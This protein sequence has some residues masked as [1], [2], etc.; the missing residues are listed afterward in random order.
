GVSR[1]ELLRIRDFSLFLGSMFAT[2]LALQMAQVAVGWQVY[3]INHRPL[4]LGLVGLA[5]FIPLPLLALPAGQLADRL[6][7]RALV[8]AAAGLGA[9]VA[10]GLLVVTLNGAN[11]VGPYFALAFLTGVA[12]AIGAPPSR[13][14]TPSLVPRE[15]LSSAFALRAVAFQV[16]AIAGPAIGG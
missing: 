5:E 1:R 3:H 8:A 11:S 16:A 4:D 15:V 14:L 6:P 2:G 9:A 13:A 10:A 12:S 7:R